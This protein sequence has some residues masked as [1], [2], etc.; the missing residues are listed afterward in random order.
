MTS[1]TQ[2]SPSLQPPRTDPPGTGARRAA[3]S[4]LDAVL[5]RG[6]T[7]EAAVGAATRGLA[8]ADDRAFA[9][10]IASEALRRLP[11]LDT[12]IDAATA[13][14]LPPDAKARGALRI[15][16]VQALAMGTPPHAAIAT[17]L[18]LVD[19]GPRKLVHGVFGTAMRS[20]ARLPDA[21]TL[22]AEVAARWDAQWGAA[23]VDA[24]SHAIAAPPAVDLTL[25]DP[26]ETERWAK[27]LGAASLMPGHLRV[28]RGARV[29]EL[30][31]YDE[32]AWWVQDISSSLPA[33]LMGHGAG[34]TALDLCAAPG[35]KAM[36]LAAAG[37]AVTAVDASTS[38]LAR[39]RENLARTGLTATIVAADMMAWGSRDRFDAVLLDA[40]CSATG[41]FRRHPETLYRARPRVI[42]EL[43]EAQ[44][45]ML[46]RAADHVAPGGTLV[47]ATCSLERAEGEDVAAEFAGT[48]R[49]FSVS[50]VAPDELQPGVL[51]DADGWVRVLPSMLAGVGGGDGFFIARFVRD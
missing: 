18:P 41:T 48:R 27:T 7:L 8:R 17:V 43:A 9:L 25:R 44:R 22:P 6:S 32:G 10:A 46:A 33:R 51:A 28:P 40:P 14:P 31:G 29:E 20:G 13:R 38:R 42:A 30:A 45:A 3:L 2:P 16:L 21:P 15:A 39:L 12:L 36:Q 50:I 19:G 11:D 37:Y 24:A 4:L 35:G 47:Y 23:E 5:R 34:R 1:H 26:V 49:D